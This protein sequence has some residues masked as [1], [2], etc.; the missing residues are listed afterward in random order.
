MRGSL[1]GCVLPLILEVQYFQVPTF[2]GVWKCMLL[3]AE[4]ALIVQC[5][6]C[7]QNLH[8]ADCG[9][10]LRR[11]ALPRHT[12]FEHVLRCAAVCCM[13]ITTKSHRSTSVS[14]PQDCGGCQ[15]AYGNVHLHVG[16]PNGVDNLHDTVP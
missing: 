11:P 5:M 15:N 16:K 1:P 6:S 10:G 4:G 14:F 13:L 12:L 3:Y 9:T 8:P 2:A 7:S